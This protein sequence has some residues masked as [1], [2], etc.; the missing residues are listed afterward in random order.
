MRR[1]HSAL[2]GLSGFKYVGL[3][4]WTGAIFTSD[5]SDIVQTVAQVANGSHVKVYIRAQTITWLVNGA[6]VAS[7]KLPSSP[8]PMFPW[9]TLS[10][11][12]VVESLKHDSFPHCAPSLEHHKATC[13]EAQTSSLEHTALPT[14]PLPRATHAV[15]SKFWRVM[16]A[17]KIQ[18]WGLNSQGQLGLGNAEG[19]KYAHGICHDTF[20]PVVGLE[21]HCRRLYGPAVE[22]LCHD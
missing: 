11:G 22:L 8:E 7:A 13:M 21:G 3:V 14:S 16:L 10:G 19:R 5:K 4:T 20:Q 2:H 18:A 1:H 6:E 17:Q 9:L 15:V 12:G